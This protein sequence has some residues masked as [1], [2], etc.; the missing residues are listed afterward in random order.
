[1][2]TPVE[3][4]LLALGRRVAEA[5]Q[6]MRDHDLR[7]KEYDRMPPDCARRI[8]GAACEEY[9]ALSGIACDLPAETLTD[10]LV[11]LAAAAS[12]IECLLA[13][14]N[15]VTRDAEADA[16][17]TRIER[18]IAS[19]IRVLL[20]VPGVLVD[21]LQRDSFSCWPTNKWKGELP[22]VQPCGLR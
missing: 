18:A 14:E 2:S 12:I 19:T 20:E 3:T 1:M 11:Q 10:A 5:E 22:A 7:G 8:N 21:G 6:R 17:C 15:V 9:Y 16:E 4:P 13:N